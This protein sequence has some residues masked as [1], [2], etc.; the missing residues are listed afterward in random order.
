MKTVLVIQ[1]GFPAEVPFFVRGLKRMGARVL[2]VGDMPR[3]SLPPVARE[4]LDAYLQVGN[5]WDAPALIHAL[6]S[7]ALPVKLDRV[8]CLWEAAMEISAHVRQAFGLPGL[9]PAHTRLFR[10]KNL[11]RQALE[12]AGIRNPRYARASTRAE[13]LEAAQQ[14]GLPLVIKPVA[15]AGSAKTYRVDS[16]EELEALLPA[17]G[18]VSEVVLEEFVQGDEYTFDTICADGQI[19]FHSI[20][21]YQPTML[22]SRTQEWVSPQNMVLRDLDTPLFQRAYALG[23]SVLRALR[24]STGFT[25]ME[26]FATP[27]GEVVFGEIAA[28]PPGGLTGELMNYC[29]DFD[30]YD[31]WGE[32]VLDGRI[33]QSMERKHN[34]AI[35]FKRAQGHGRI[36][37]VEGLEGLYRRFG[38]HII[39]HQLQPPGAPRRDW[40]KTLLSDGY[41]IL[42]HPDLAAA[43]AMSADV[44]ENLRLIAG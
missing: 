24:F 3:G 36:Q 9:S 28:R 29:C 14:V 27:Q 4:G 35:I 7:W 5:L 40:R 25:H 43:T 34:V 17:F 15:G 11:M 12:Q 16:I 33:S 8:E 10:D 30:V 26:W 20:L 39:R 19:L 1:P 21:R 2:G 23:A 13:V 18:A 42:R 32:A 31:A 38:R 6:R 22:E 44:A 37:R 41:L